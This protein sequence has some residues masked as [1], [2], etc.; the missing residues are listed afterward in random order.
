MHLDDYHACGPREQLEELQAEISKHVRVKEWFI[1]APGEHEEYEHLHRKRVMKHD[2]T[3][4]KANSKH[5]EQVQELLG[6]QECKP[7]PTPAIKNKKE[8]AEDA[9]ELVDVDREV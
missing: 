1:H 3:W 6:L 7:A 9:E 2:G 4:I 5:I 8:S